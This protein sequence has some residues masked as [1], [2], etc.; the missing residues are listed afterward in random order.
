[1]QDRT[2]RLSRAPVQRWLGIRLLH[3]H[4]FALWKSC[5]RRFSAR[6]DLGTL[7]LGGVVHVLDACAARLVVFLAIGVIESIVILDKD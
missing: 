3:Y 2:S 1:M 6:M 5:Q 7:T 4:L